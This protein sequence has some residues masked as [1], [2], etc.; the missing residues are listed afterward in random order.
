MV[1]DGER[2][3]SQGIQKAEKGIKKEMRKEA[4]ITE[5]FWEE[6]R[7]KV[8]NESGIRKFINKLRG[9]K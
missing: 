5:K 7:S 9:K 8:K 2:V 6:I 3:L 1:E 4:E